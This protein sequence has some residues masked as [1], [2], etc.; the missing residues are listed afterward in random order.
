[1]IIHNLNID[2]PVALGPF[3]ADSPLVVYA[4]TELA[5]SVA[6]QGFKSVTWWIPKVNEAYR[7]IQSIQRY[8]CS[9]GWNTLKSPH[10][11]AVSKLFRI[12]ISILWPC[13]HIDMLRHA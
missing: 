4:N 7:R 5:G 11:L 12:T 6:L 10:E 8:I 1:M 3:K 13:A 2:G 9:L